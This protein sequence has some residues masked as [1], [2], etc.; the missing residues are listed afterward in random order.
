MFRDVSTGATGVTRVAP[1]F[2]DTL[3]LFQTGGGRLCPPLARS[4]LKFPRGYV[5][6]VSAVLV[7]SDKKLTTPA[8]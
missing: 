5:P 1:K 2:S 8:L 7:E 4:H 3:T 6:G